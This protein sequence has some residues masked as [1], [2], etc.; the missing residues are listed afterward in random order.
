MKQVKHG[1]KRIIGVLI[2]SNLVA[3]AQRLAAGQPLAYGQSITD[4]CIAWDET[5]ELLQE[6]ADTVRA[7]RR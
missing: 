4:P 1:E 5:F 3:G 6:L 7:A 2:E